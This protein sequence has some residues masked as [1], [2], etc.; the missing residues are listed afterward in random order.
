VY[1]AASI[2]GSRSHHHLSA[3]QPFFISRTRFEDQQYRAATLHGLL[4]RLAIREEDYIREG[5]FVLRST[6]MNPWHGEAQQA[7][8]D[9]LYEFVRF[10]H[11][12][13]AESLV[14]EQ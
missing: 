6:V 3:A 14:S 10:L 12:V 9:Y 8:M 2:P 1:S 13:T 7:G 5:L 11:R 4:D